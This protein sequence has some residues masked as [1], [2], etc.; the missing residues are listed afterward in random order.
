MHEKGVAN[1]SAANQSEQ[2]QGGVHLA[3]V[4]SLEA[5]LGDGFSRGVEL[6]KMHDDQS[7]VDSETRAREED[8]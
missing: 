6:E 3:V 2:E 8:P 5:T 7:D 4:G 1:G